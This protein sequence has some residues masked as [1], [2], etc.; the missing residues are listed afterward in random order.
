MGAGPSPGTKPNR[1]PN[2]G[3]QCGAVRLRLIRAVAERETA[4]TGQ[5]G[6]EVRLHRQP[7]GWLRSSHSFKEC[8]TA[9]WSSS[10][11]PT[12]QRG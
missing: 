12:I 8:V 9:H 1:T 6:K 2:A 11:A 4:Q 7:G 10:R 3:A 5:V